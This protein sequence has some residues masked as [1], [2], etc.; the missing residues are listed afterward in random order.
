MR[1]CW[2]FRGFAVKL[3]RFFVIVAGCK[4]T[5]SFFEIGHCFGLH[6][7]RLRYQTLACANTGKTYRRWGSGSMFP[8]T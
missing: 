1:S 3:R 7:M 2:W 4:F 6:F 5:T 8:I